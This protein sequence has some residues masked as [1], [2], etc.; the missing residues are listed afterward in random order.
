MQKIAGKTLTEVIHV[1]VYLLTQALFQ[2]LVC[3]FTAY[4]KLP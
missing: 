1:C 2:N 3:R 4:R